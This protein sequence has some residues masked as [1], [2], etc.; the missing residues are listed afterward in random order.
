MRP[1]PCSTCR[2]CKP[3]ATTNPAPLSAT[4]STPFRQ[5]NPN[6]PETAVPPRPEGRLYPDGPVA[7]GVVNEGGGTRKT[8]NAANL[9]VA[10]ARM[11]LKVGVG[12]GDPTMQ[13]SAYLG[14]GLS[15]R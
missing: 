11:G 4:S 1:T 9:A 7:F 14:R 15:D 8:T 6:P 10:L 5:R 12:D 2:S 3:R 13:L